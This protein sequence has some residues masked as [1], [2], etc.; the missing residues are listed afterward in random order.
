[1][2]HRLTSATLRPAITGSNAGGSPVARDL[3]VAPAGPP[4]WRHTLI[5]TGSLNAG[6]AP[7]LQEEVE[8]LCQEGVTSIVL[9]LRRLQA[10]DAVG[11]QTLAA[12]PALY[13]RRGLAI[14]VIGGAVLASHAP[15]QR[16]NLEVLMTERNGRSELRR[17]RASPDEALPTRSTEMVKVL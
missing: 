11:G 9:D 16:E 2:N 3:G 14:A 15:M 7:E 8:C 13:K 1:M 17:F 12:L 5:L 6:S 4:A 10:I